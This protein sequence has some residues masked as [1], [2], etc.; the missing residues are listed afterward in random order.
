MDRGDAGK[1]Y[2][3]TGGKIINGL[4]YPCQLTLDVNATT[5]ALIQFLLLDHSPTKVDPR[6]NIS[7]ERAIQIAKT[8]VTLKQ[9]EFR[10]LL[11]MDASGQIKWIV[12]ARA[13]I[14]QPYTEEDGQI[15]YVEHEI[16][17]VDAKSGRYLGAMRGPDDPT[18]IRVIRPP[19]KPP[20]VL[21]QDYSAKWT[22]DGSRIFFTSSRTTSPEFSRFERREIC[23][24]TPQGEIKAV[25]LNIQGLG[26]MEV[27]PNGK[28]IAIDLGQ[29]QVAILDIENGSLGFCNNYDRFLLSMPSWAS[30]GEHMV[31]VGQE[32]TEDD[33]TGKTG[34]YYCEISKKLGGHSLNS[35][36]LLFES[37]SELLFPVLSPNNEDLVFARQES[38]E[39]SVDLKSKSGQ[40]EANDS[41]KWG[42]YRLHFGNKIRR[43]IECE[44]ITDLPEE[45]ERISWFSGS[46]AVAVSYPIVSDWVSRA[47]D[48]VD[49]KLKSRQPLLRNPLRDPEFPSYPSLVPQ[50]VS[51]GPLGDKLLFS[52]FL[53]DKK[54]G[55][56][57]MYCLYTCNTDGS[58]LRRITSSRTTSPINEQFKRRDLTPQNFWATLSTVHQ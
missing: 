1:V 16:R 46:S 19:V 37:T 56:K 35:R 13:T 57:A 49:L 30:D 52:A 12:D 39:T 27:A 45:P 26:N 31:A 44:R 2:L 33:S 50:S 5:G 3:I 20:T 17:I 10:T 34:I 7:R 54:P 9:P 25:V 28:R 14:I 24:T 32:V 40:S 53:W 11:S 8:K 47:A 29:M 38:G 21:F 22:A 4:G 48:I 55:T 42:L 36:T 43:V 51:V 23:S 15:S 58:G 41:E 18:D 6:V